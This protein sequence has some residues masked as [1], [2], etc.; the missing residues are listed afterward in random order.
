MAPRYVL[1]IMDRTLRDIMQNNL[2]FG[3]KIILLGGDFRQLLPIKV[4]S[5]RS[6]VV[7]LSIKFSFLWKQF[8][9]F[10]LT[11]NLRVLPQEK[12][13]AQFL[14]DL[15]NGSLNDQSDNIQIPERC[16]ANVNADIVKEMYVDI[17]AR[18]QYRFI[19]NNIILSARNVDVDEINE[20]VINLLDET[21]ERL[22]TSVD[23]E[24]TNNEDI[25][26][27]F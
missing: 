10:S 15:G 5:T 18:K 12:E 25:L 26:K 3:G 22:Y 1:E 27:L 8:K 7:N 20:K 2:Y 16:I 11:E 6:E 21:T 24:T 23:V 17:I 14:L 13:F 9:V 19:A 4:R